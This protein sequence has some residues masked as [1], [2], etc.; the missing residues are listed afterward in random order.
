MKSI[1]EEMGGTYSDIN[2]Y[3]IPNLSMPDSPPLG[4]WGRMRRRYLKKQ[5]PA[6]YS[7]MLLTGRLDQHLAEIDKAC[8]KQMEL[9]TKQMAQREGVTE[10][11]KA[12]DQ[13]AWVCRMNNIRNRAEE[14]VLQEL[15]YSD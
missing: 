7:S 4:R 15:I 13:M 10:A 6:L 8:E 12:T 14:I 3:L 2:G 1:F 11:L 9:L 5:R